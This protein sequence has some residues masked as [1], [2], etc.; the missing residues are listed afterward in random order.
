MK[1][2]GEWLN[3]IYSKTPNGVSHVMSRHTLYLHTSTSAAAKCIPVHLVT[4]SYVCPFQETQ[5]FFRAKDPQYK[6]KVK[7]L[8]SMEPYESRRWV[9]V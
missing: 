5:E 7:V 3:V 4:I 6:K 8:E 2:E 9:K 1:L